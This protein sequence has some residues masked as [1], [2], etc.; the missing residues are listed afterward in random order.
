M[1][2]RRS[3]G[4]NGFRIADMVVDIICHITAFLFRIRQVVF[5]V[6]IVFLIVNDPLIR[7]SN[8]KQLL[9]FVEE[10]I[11]FISRCSFQFFY[12]F[13][14]LALNLIRHHLVVFTTGQLTDPTVDRLVKIP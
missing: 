9:Q 4:H 8:P 6:I 7:R 2:I 14:C 10:L 5:L 3:S 11:T 13:F 1:G 12:L